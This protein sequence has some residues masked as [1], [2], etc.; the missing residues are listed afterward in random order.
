MAHE[1]YCPPVTGHILHLAQAL[2]LELS[3]A[4]SKNFVDDQDFRLQ[5]GGN[6]KGQTHVHAG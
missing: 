3:V 6:S 1:Q 2:L 5:M 4:D